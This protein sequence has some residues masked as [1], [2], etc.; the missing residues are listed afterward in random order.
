MVAYAWGVPDPVVHFGVGAVA[1]AAG[2]VAAYPFDYIKSQ[3][4]AKESSSDSSTAG[5]TETSN[6]S[7][8]RQWENGYEAFIDIVSE[9]GPLQLY[10]GVG[11]QVAGIAPEKGIKLGVNDV[12]TTAFQTANNGAFPLWCQVISGATAGACQVLASSPLEVLKVGLQTSERDLQ[13][14][15]SDIGGFG[16]L[17]RGAEACIARDVLFTAVCFPLYNYL[18]ESDTPRKFR[19]NGTRKRVKATGTLA[20]ITLL[21]S[22]S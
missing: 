2:A 18:V 13:Q 22:I 12:L 5:L 16:G 6:S 8:H 14:V 9:R 1:G 21:L 15:W 4:Q 10:K 7:S 19:V 3:M 20:D 11:V 17:F